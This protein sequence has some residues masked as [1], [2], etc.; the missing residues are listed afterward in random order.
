MSFS[1]KQIQAIKRIPNHIEC[2]VHGYIRMAQ[3]LLSDDTIIPDI[4]IV[5]CLLFYHSFRDEWDPQNMA[6][7]AELLQDNIIQFTKTN[8]GNVFCK[9]ILKVCEGTDY[10]WK[11]KIIKYDSDISFY[12]YNL[13]IGIWNCDIKDN[14]D[15]IKKAVA[16]DNSWTEHNRQ[17]YALIATNGSVVIP[18]SSALGSS[19]VQYALKAQQNP[20]EGDIIEMKLTGL[21]IKWTTKYGSVEYKVK[22]GNYRAVLSARCNQLDTTLKIQILDI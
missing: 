5:A 14:D 16:A 6:K 1:Q 8:A 10:E 7:T 15:L 18:N 13:F 20:A 4:V 2:L 3:N 22:K 12:F 17:R 11:F 19:S 9:Q 21:T